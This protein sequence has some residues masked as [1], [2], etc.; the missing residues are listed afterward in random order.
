M[1]AIDEE[2]L[3]S[4]DPGSPNSEPSDLRSYQEL[5][6]KNGSRTINE[7]IAY[8]PNTYSNL[9][10]SPTEGYDHANLFA[11][12]A[13]RRTTS[14]SEKDELYWDRRERNN[15]SAKRCRVKRRLNDIA[16]ESRIMELTK[17]NNVLRA[18]IEAA[19]LREQVTV[20]SYENNKFSNNGGINCGTNITPFSD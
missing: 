8:H 15:E 13:E 12:R 6:K 7:D 17:E 2:P 1:D 10:H 5:E 16:L 19:R 4:D 11:V 9:A 20:S 3:L 18:K 14:E